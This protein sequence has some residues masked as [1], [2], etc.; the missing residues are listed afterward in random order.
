MKN[1]IEMEKYQTPY[2]NFNTPIFI[3][4]QNQVI[5]EH[6]FFY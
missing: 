6:Y 4:F 2:F 3:S 5:I 1:E